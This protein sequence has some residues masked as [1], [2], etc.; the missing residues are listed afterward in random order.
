MNPQWQWHRRDALDALKDDLVHKEIWREDAGGYVD[1]SPPP[2]KTTTVQIQERSRDEETG[3][4]ELKIIPVHGDT[5]YAEV[6]EA[7]PASQKVDNGLYVTDEIE[8]SFL[9]V[10]PTG[11][12][13]NGPAV[14]WKNS[15]TL[16][17]RFFTGAAGERMLELKVAPN[18]DTVVRYTT[19]GPT[20]KL[21]AA[22]MG[23]LC[24]QEGHS[25]RPCHAECDG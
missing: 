4:V 16:R 25:T 23:S 1:R 10:D 15:V 8:V 19:D 7:T 13:P 20:Q 18:R 24:R 2:A 9:A 11:V 12:H 14:T 22:P 21:P 17:Y 3:Q 5:V 6:G